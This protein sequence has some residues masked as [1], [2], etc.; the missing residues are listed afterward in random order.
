MARYRVNPKC[1]VCGG[2]RLRGGTRHAHD[3]A[4]HEAVRAARDEVCALRR[5]RWPR[6]AWLPRAPRL[7][8]PPEWACIVRAGVVYHVLASRVDEIRGEQA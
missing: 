5:A 3:A 7:V 8:R 2:P 1:I 6:A 4:R